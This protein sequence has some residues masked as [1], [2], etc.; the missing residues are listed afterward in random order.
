[1]SVKEK[2]KYNI[3]FRIQ[4]PQRN[5][6]RKTQILKLRKKM[7]KTKKKK[8]KKIPTSSINT[9]SMRSGLKPSTFQG[10][11]K[12]PKV[13]LLPHTIHSLK[14]HPKTYCF[15]YTP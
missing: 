9:T 11:R 12:A 13:I 4:L 5:Q 3:T 15:E 6:K 7:K 2:K 10:K 8:R 1:M 14:S